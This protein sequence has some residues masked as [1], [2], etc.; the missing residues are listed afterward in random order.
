MKKTCA[1]VTLVVCLSV[2][3]SARS[4]PAPPATGEVETIDV[5]GAIGTSIDGINAHGDLAGSY[6]TPDF[7][8]HGFVRIRGGFETLD[9]PGATTVRTIPTGINAKGDVVGIY[10]TSDPCVGCPGWLENVMLGFVWREGQFETLQVPGSAYTSPRGINARGHVAGEYWSDKVYGF[11]WDGSTYHTVDLAESPGP[12]SWSAGRAINAGGDL[13]GW[14]GSAE[15]WVF[16]GYLLAKGQRI[17]IDG[18]GSTWTIAT[19]INAERTVVGWYVNSVGEQHG[20]A[21]RAGRITTIDIPGGVWT[22]VNDI[23]DR[24]QMVG[25]YGTPDGVAHGFVLS[26]K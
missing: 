5:P 21:W 11:V 17:T 23:N 4:Q 14:Y 18:P 8:V 6:M 7:V 25:Q 24:G 16:H 3:A 10:T 1:F 13:A 12:L 22:A 20:F 19:G 9:F 15:T 26:S 2:Y